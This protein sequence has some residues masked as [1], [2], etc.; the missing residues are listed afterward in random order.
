MTTLVAI[1]TP[2][3]PAVAAAKV[4]VRAAVVPRSVETSPEPV[5]AAPASDD[6]DA[7]PFDDAEGYDDAEG[8]GDVLAAK[9]RRSRNNLSRRT[10]A[11]WSAVVL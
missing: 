11:R 2:A 7:E 6:L 8:L 4:M 1:E 3:T 10:I 9:H 5:A